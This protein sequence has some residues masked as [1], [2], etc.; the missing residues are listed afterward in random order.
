LLFSTNQLAAW[1][2][3]HINSLSL[4]VPDDLAIISFDD[5][6]ALDLFYTPLTLIKQPLQEM[7][8]TATKI[9]LDSLGKKCDTVQV[10]LQAE[11]II[12][13]STKASKPA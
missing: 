12:R 5:T 3:K 7:G 13:E 8:R 6:E 11:L 10:S 1:G 4:T 2:L 9:L